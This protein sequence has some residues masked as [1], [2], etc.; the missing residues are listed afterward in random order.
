MVFKSNN[1]YEEEVRELKKEGRVT[2]KEHTEFCKE[3]M[4]LPNCTANRVA[5]MDLG[6]DS[7]KRKAWE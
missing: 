2:G 4:G 1:R 3:L 6:R 7:R 5:K